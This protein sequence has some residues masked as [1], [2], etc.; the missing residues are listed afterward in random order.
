MLDIDEINE[1]EKQTID[2]LNF[3]QAKL[4]AV[5]DLLPH[6]REALHSQIKRD[7]AQIKKWRFRMRQTI[8]KLNEPLDEV[9]TCLR[10]LEALERRP[11]RILKAPPNALIDYEERKSRH[12]TQGITFYKLFWVF[13]LGCFAGVVIETIWCFI[14][15]GRI[16]SRTALV[17]GPL[18]PVYGLGALVLTVA[19]YKYRNR[20]KLYSFI[21]GMIAGSAVEYF[22]SWIQETIFGSTSWDYSAK[23]FNLNGRICLEYSIFWGIL[24]I[25]WIKALYPRM[26]QLILKIPNKHGKTITWCLFVFVAINGLVSAAA[27]YRWAER[28]SGVPA[29]NIVEQIIDDRF[30]DARMES[31]YPTLIFA[32]KGT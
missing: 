4:S 26:V 28:N 24:G 8:N 9:E 16:E 11:L 13:L 14:R 29:S 20:S 23:P 25:L 17:W 32:D 19:L 12:F 6:E 3:Y 31:L 1:L 10:E 30:S 18:N 7:I 22:C 15:Y 2:R 5:T 21:G 27:V